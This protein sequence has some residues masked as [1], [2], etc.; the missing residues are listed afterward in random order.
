MGQQF[1]E[2]P[3]SQTE[4]PNVG[5]KVAT[6]LPEFK[7]IK[8]TVLG[9]GS[10]GTALAYVLAMSGHDVTI[11]CRKAEVCASI[12]DHHINPK[13]FSDKILPEN[14]K[15][16]PDLAKAVTSATHIFHALPAQVTA[17]FLAGNRKLFL[18]QQKIVVCTAKGIDAK[19]GLLMSQVFEEILGANY[20]CAFLSGPSF[21]KEMLADHPMAVTIAS[22]D[23]QV[24]M[25]AQSLFDK[26][27]FRCYYSP[28]VIGVEI[29][30]ALKNP[31]AIGAGMARGKGFGQSTIAGI[32]TRGVVE[33]QKLCVAMGG[34]VET[35][36]GLSGMGD[37]MLT[38][39]SS[40]SRN[41]RFGYLI[42]SEGLSLEEAAERIGE[43]VEG[44]PT[45][46]VVLKKMEEYNVR[47]P[48]FQC[49]GLVLAGKLE[50]DAAMDLAMSKS[51]IGVEEMGELRA[52]SS[53]I[54]VS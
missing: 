11:W 15:A 41:N 47:M 32:V 7:E 2:E 48:L 50:V 46:A 54:E 44:A 6:K 37:L 30:G 18:E 51:T 36:Q 52:A 13:R 4:A 38:C 40:L 31:L 26:N 21:A 10:Y 9:A 5:E 8:C 49:V 39:F 29:G 24:G 19:S 45:A 28:D 33:M 17:G 27:R 23:R 35:L 14:L 42:G 53:T 3:K 20:P 25:S 1:S 16:E 22:K 34:Q 12:N 43:V